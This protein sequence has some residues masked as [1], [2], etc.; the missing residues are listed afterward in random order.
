MSDYVLY[1]YF[2][3]ST[4]FRVRIAMHL[5]GLSFKYAPV[6]LL[7]NGGEQ[8]SEEYR[9]LNPASEVPT[10]VQGSFRL[11]QSMAI[12][13]Y[14]D[15]AHPT[16]KLFPMDSQSGARVRQFCEN[17]NCV[18]ALTNLK[19]MAYLEKNFAI[20]AGQKTQWI[21]HWFHK[22]FSTS[23][24]L[25]KETAGT[26]C[27][28]SEITAADLFLVPQVFSGSRFEVDMTPFPL[29]RQVTE[30]ALKHPAF[31]AAH[32]HRQIDTPSELRLP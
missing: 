4:S 31:Q 3:S 2:R 14:L 30:N 8:H 5:K 16:P 11:A 19:V 23:E 24:T 12:L 28:G 17:I 10:L 25:L 32:P 29:I 9:Q 6:H 21:Q 1:N 20:N 26:Y 27:F 18:H 13:E 15:V 22:N 7:N